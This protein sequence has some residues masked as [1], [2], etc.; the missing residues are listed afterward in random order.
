MEMKLRQLFQLIPRR[1]L[2]VQ[3]L[4]LLSYSYI[5]QGVFL[6]INL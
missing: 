2:N 3:A 6:S 4:N 5:Q 1:Y